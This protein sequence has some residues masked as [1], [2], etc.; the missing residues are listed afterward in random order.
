[1]IKAIKRVF[2]DWSI[3]LYINPDKTYSVVISYFDIN[4]TEEKVFN[5][6]KKASD[7]FFEIVKEGKND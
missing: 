5:N 2:E 4:T 3:N 1:M 7:K 6:F